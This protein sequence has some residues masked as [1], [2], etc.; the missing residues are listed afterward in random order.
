MKDW[1]PDLDMQMAS[2]FTCPTPQQELLEELRVALQRMVFRVVRLLTQWLPYPR[3]SV[4][5]DG[6]CII[7]ATL[8][9]M[10]SYIRL[11]VVGHYV[12]AWIP[13]E[14]IFIHELPLQDRIREAGSRVYSFKRFII[15]HCFPKNLQQWTFTGFSNAHILLPQH[16]IL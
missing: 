15:L 4:P 11:K 7:P 6:S 13:G 9:V 16:P 2:L 1:L 10:Q 12:K 8:L 3:A 5:R 14:V